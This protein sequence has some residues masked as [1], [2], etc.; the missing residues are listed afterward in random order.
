M[1]S[2]ALLFPVSRLSMEATDEGTALLLGTLL[3]RIEPAAIFGGL[4]EVSNSQ[5]RAL[6]GALSILAAEGIEDVIQYS[7]PF[8]PNVLA[9]IDLLRRHFVPLAKLSD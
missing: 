6:L 9:Q 2:M 4:D 8:R 3:G 5:L 1:R 7:A